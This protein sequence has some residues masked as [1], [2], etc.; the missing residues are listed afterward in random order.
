MNDEFLR[1]FFRTLRPKGLLTREPGEP[2]ETFEQLQQ[3]ALE[4]ERAE[5]AQRAAHSPVGRDFA[6]L[7]DNELAA[8]RPPNDLSRQEKRRTAE[9]RSSRQVAEKANPPPSD[10]LAD[11]SEQVRNT[12]KA[13]RRLERLLA[14]A[15][16]D[17]RRWKAQGRILDRA[18]TPR[19]GH[20]VFDRAVSIG[21]AVLKHGATPANLK[22]AKKRRDKHKSDLAE[23]KRH[24]QRVRER[25]RQTQE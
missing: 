19:T 9:Q 10:G 24:L 25:L 20:K 13:V 6:S 4:R 22:S 3:R 18:R 23:A 7:G 14:R 16:S 11:A 12:E 17:I 2:R 5:E 21:R 1:N 15:E 8:R